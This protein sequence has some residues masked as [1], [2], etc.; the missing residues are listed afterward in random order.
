MLKTVKVHYCKIN[1]KVAENPLKKYK[2]KF[3]IMVNE[4]YNF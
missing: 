3:N 1:N 2:V 4:M